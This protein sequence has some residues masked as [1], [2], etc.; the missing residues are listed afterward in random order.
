MSIKEVNYD[1]PVPLRI[2][3]ESGNY[4]RIKYQ[5]IPVSYQGENTTSRYISHFEDD[6]EHGYVYHDLQ[7]GKSVTFKGQWVD[8][9]ES[10]TTQERVLLFRENE[11][12]CVPINESI[13]HLKVSNQEYS[14]ES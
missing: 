5:H 13:L 2:D 11:V 12:I 7:S 3:S 8:N 14:S 10:K 1:S 4:M 6:P 9:T